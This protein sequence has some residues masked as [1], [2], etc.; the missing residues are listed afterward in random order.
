MSDRAYCPVDGCDYWI[1]FGGY[2][3]PFIKQFYRHWISHEE[4]AWAEGRV[5]G[6]KL[7]QI[8]GQAVIAALPQLGGG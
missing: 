8:L 2:F 4:L 1:V 3:Q 6:G 5:P 7:D